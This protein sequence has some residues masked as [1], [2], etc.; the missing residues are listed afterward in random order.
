ME[1]HEVTSQFVFDGSSLWDEKGTYSVPSKDG[2]TRKLFFITPPDPERLERLA[3]LANKFRPDK[4]GGE[5]EKKFLEE[6][7]L[8]P[9]QV[10][11]A[12]PP[13]VT[14]P[15]IPKSFLFGEDSSPEKALSAVRRGRLR[16]SVWFLSDKSRATMTRQ[17]RGDA[18]ALLRSMAD[19]AGAVAFL[20]GKGFA[21]C[22]L[23]DE[24]VLLDTA[25]GRAFLIGAEN[26]WAP[27][28]PSPPPSVPIAYA[29]PELLG[30][31]RTKGKPDLQA[32]R[33]ADLHALAVLFYRLLLRR[34][35]LVGPKLTYGADALFIED[36]DDAS[37]RPDNLNV[38]IQELGDPLERLFLDAFTHGLRVPRERPTALRWENALKTAL[39]RLE[40]RK[41]NVTTAKQASLAKRREGVRDGEITP[42]GAGSGTVNLNKDAKEEALRTWKLR[43]EWRRTEKFDL[44]VSAF[45]RRGERGAASSKDMIF[46]GNLTHDSNSVRILEDAPSDSQQKAEKIMIVERDLI[47]ADVSRIDFVVSAYYANRPEYVFK[48]VDGPV[49]SVC[50]G[51][52][53]VLMSV[54]LRKEFGDC[55][56]CVAA[57]LIRRDGQMAL[58]GKGHGYRGGL[59]AVCA[60]YGIPVTR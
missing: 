1:K 26:F 20:H 15:A 51:D 36:P 37:N 32:L 48:E 17:E 24:T 44:D 23:S 34:H 3:A 60:R 21:C 59:N 7:I 4:D 52:D 41:G 33:D 38:T 42:S 5:T 39:Q 6:H 45:L 12:P 30:P 19:L 50:D 46:Y 18:S 22:G 35:P 10:L 40:E 11:F 13:S 27:D 57:S 29:A 47:P 28:F 8:W 25:H 2:A 49:L 53:D 55:S 14:W 54:D 43:L 58:T 31:G 16:K 9:R 56:A